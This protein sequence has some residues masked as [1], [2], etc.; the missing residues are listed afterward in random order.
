LLAYVHRGAQRSKLWVR[1]LKTWERAEIAEAAHGDHPGRPL[2]PSWVGDGYL[3]WSAPQEGSG[4]ADEGAWATFGALI[5]K[6]P[7]RR[8]SSSGLLGPKTT[9]PERQPGIPTNFADAMVSRPGD[10]SLMDFFS[11][12][13]VSHGADTDDAPSARRAVPRVS[14]VVSLSEQVPTEEFELGSGARF[15]STSGRWIGQDGLPIHECHHPAFDISGDHVMC[16]A[17]KVGD[18]NQETAFATGPGGP[19]VKLNYLYRQTS[20][21]GWGDPVLPFDPGTPASLEA[22]LGA[23]MP[24]A[25][26]A[27]L[28]SYK[29]AEFCGTDDFVITT[30]YC[31]ADRKEPPTHSR[32]LIVQRSQRRIWDLT[33]WVED[34]LGQP[35]GALSAQSGTCGSL[36]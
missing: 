9:R 32:V 3:L 15:D 33:A 11:M 35:R 31:K 26:C 16:H 27:A 34:L 4:P 17:H 24:Q 21:Q 2:F 29:F 30:L 25:D 12:R 19:V 20:A 14:P 8:L 10:F 36:R 5:G 7:L 28:Y 13:L 1:D 6:G 23:A 18:E 22:A